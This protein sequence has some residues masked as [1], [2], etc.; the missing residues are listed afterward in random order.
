MR[1][2]LAQPLALV[3]SMVMLV[4]LA[5]CGVGLKSAHSSP[6][7]PLRAAGTPRHTIAAP[8]AG[9]YAAAIGTAMLVAAVRLRDSL[10]LA[11]GIIMAQSET[12]VSSTQTE[13][14]Q[15]A[16]EKLL[17]AAL[18]ACEMLALLALCARLFAQD[19]RRRFAAFWGD[20]RPAPLSRLTNHR[21]APAP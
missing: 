2:V 18:L 21:I 17:A 10:A 6:P 3:M 14:A 9:I 12:P 1:K 20:V 13:Q 19:A 11:A 7:Q 5:V 8:A 15:T 16:S 4:A